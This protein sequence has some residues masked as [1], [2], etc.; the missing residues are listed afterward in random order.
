MQLSFQTNKQ[1]I[2]TNVIIDLSTTELACKITDRFS[3]RLFVL[4]ITSLVKSRLSVILVKT[5]DLLRIAIT[6]F[7]IF[8]YAILH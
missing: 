1:T 3:E 7:V 6:L 4:A 8:H 2:Q 5:V